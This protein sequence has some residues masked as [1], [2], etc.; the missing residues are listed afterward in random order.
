[1]IDFTQP[2]RMTVTASVTMNTKVMA[3]DEEHF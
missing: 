3:D 1:M 2:M